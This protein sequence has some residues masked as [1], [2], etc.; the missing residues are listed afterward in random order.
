MAIKEVNSLP[1][2]VM[3]VRY[4]CSKTP[5]RCHDFFLISQEEQ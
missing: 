3:M 4:S 2:N 5:M 1:S